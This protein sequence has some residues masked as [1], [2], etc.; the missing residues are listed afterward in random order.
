MEVFVPSGTAI[1]V[2]GGDDPDAG[3]SAGLGR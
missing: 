3:G 1:A 2:A